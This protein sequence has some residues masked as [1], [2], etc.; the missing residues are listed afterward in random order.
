MGR[1]AYPLLL[2]A[3]MLAVPSSALADTTNA[4]SLQELFS[5]VM[6]QHPALS[7]K[8]A[9]VKAKA[10]A[11]DSAR[12]GRYPSLNG[13]AGYQNLD[14]QGGSQ[15]NNQT[16][17]TLRARQPLWA[18]GRIDSA[19]DYAD[20]D[21]LAN[22]ADLLRVKRDLLEKTAVAYARILGLYQRQQVVA[23]N[24]ISHEQFYQ[25]IQ[26]R[27][28]GQ[29]ASKA[30]STLAALRLIQARTQ[31]K[32][33]E[34]ELLLALNEL[35]ALTQMPV[36]QVLPMADD[37]VDLPI[38]MND[39]EQTALE[40]SA[41]LQHKELLVAL[42]EAKAEQEKT[43]SM[44]TIYLQ[45]EKQFNQLGINNGE[46]YGVM[47]EGGVDGMGLPAL[48][49][50]RAAGAQKVAAMESLKVSRNELIRNVRSLMRNRQLQQ[51]LIEA[52]T[53]SEGEFQAVLQSYMRQYEAGRKPW[54]EVL[55]IQRELTEQRL[56][57]VQ[58]KSDWLVYS[59]RLMT[60]IGGFD[61]LAGS[62]KE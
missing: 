11:S 27:E 59:L 47:V 60:L 58:A 50:A 5:A 53:L 30:D 56:Q 33:I 37:V 42:A 62:M 23:G 32:R 57:L 8:R 48:G 3:G 6:A 1:P 51:D 28:L 31:E 34:G 38:M 24:I 46:R 29:L 39:V 14:A 18:F 36:Q 44:P 2:V 10:F 26:R 19:I 61:D 12:A 35:Q 49:R 45:A 13:Q 40:N 43:A 9:E 16:S 54:L 20:A 41:N 52:Q 17:F 7:G 22:Q 4:F 55:N 15:T 21:V 25:Q